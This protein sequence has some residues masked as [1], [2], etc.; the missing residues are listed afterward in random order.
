MGSTKLSE[1][2][3]CVIYNYSVCPDSE[4]GMFVKYNSK[5]LSGLQLFDGHWNSTIDKKKREH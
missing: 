5:G 4:G 3:Q 1:T 2:T